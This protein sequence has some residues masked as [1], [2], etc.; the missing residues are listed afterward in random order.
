[1]EDVLIQRNGGE[2]ELSEEMSLFLDAKCNERRRAGWRMK[3][4]SKNEV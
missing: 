1:M 2:E 4:E 3:G